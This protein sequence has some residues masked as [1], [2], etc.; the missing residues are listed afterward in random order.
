MKPDNNNTLF[1]K[2]KGRGVK[3]QIKGNQFSMGVG[4]PFD[5]PAIK[6]FPGPGQYRNQFIGPTAPSY[7]Q[8]TAGQVVINRQ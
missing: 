8:A 4:M 3:K 5:D 6:S 2:D 1:H 7:T